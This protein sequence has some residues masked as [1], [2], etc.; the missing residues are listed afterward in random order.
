[1]K[2]KAAGR[3]K[4]VAVVKGKIAG[5]FAQQVAG[6][7]RRYRPALEVLAKR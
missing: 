6:F 3:K 4:V 1:M 5:S 2:K 7:I